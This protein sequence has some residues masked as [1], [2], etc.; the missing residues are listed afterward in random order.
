MHDLTPKDSCEVC[1][2]EVGLCRDVRVG[3]VKLFGPFEE[4]AAFHKGVRGGIESE[5]GERFLAQQ[6]MRVHER[7]YDIKFTH[8]DLGVQSI[9]I[10]NG[11]V[12]AIVDWECAVW[13]PE[14][15]EYTKAHGL[16]KF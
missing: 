11:R 2:T 13:Y 12:A 14:Y 16:C 15:W 9:L 1:S 8:G 6:V 4:R 3:S 10:R 7:K 5:S